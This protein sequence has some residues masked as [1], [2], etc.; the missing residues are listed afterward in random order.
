MPGVG[1]ICIPATATP[2]MRV[3]V[4]KPDRNCLVFFRAPDDAIEMFRVIHGARE[5]D[6]I[7]DEIQLELE[8]E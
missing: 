8:D 4:V 5:L 2:G 1:T 6:R 3:A 7:V